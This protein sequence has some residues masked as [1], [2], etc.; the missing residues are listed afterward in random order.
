MAI[1]KSSDIKGQLVAPI[2][3]DAGDVHETIIMWDTTT[4][5]D[6]AL[7]SGD[8][9]QLMRLPAGCVLVDAQVWSS[10]T[11][12]TATFALGFA[13]SASASTNA[14]TLIAAAAVTTSVLQATR[15]AISAATPAANILAPTDDENILGVLVATAAANA[16][17]K[18][19]VAFK[20][21][22]ARAGL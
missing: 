19:Y 12:G 9:L 16:G 10:A 7:A 11:L 4:T 1:L 17:V 5:A 2:P 14:S 15:I 3:N 21:R 6:G 8:Y 13:T 18:L 20:Y 22:V